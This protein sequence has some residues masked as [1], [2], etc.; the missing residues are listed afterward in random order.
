MSEKVS[1][2]VKAKEKLELLINKLQNGDVL[3]VTRM[4]HLGRNTLQLL[5]LVE[6]LEQK[7]V[8]L[9]IL[10]M[11]IDTRTAA[12]KFFLTVMAGFSVR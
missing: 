2:V 9:V 6:Q 4:D 7:N 5:E 8:H 10:N 11:N 12:G 1:R 3:V